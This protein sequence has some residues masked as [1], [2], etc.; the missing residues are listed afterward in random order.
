MK[1][2][3]NG[4]DLSQFYTQM[5][6][7]GDDKSAARSLDLGLVVSGTDRNLPAPRV[8]MRDPVQVYSDEGL[9]FFDG[10]VMDKEKSVDSNTM[11]VNCMD[12]LIQANTSQGSFTFEDKDPSQIASEALS[13]IGLSPGTLE[14][15]SPLSRQF[16]LKSIYNIVHTAYYL[17]YEKSGKPFI[18][19]MNN[20]QVEVVEKG[21]TMSKWQLDGAYNLLNATYGESSKDAI[22]T[23]RIFD[24]EGKEIG[25]VTNDIKAGGTEIYRQEKDEDP[26]ARA[27]KLLKGIERRASIR[28]LGNFDLIT[29]NGVYIKEPF[30]GLI[31]KFFITGDTHTFSD[32]KHVV[33]LTLSYEN[34]MENID[35]SV[36]DSQGLA[37][38]SMALSGDVNSKVLQA[39]Q[40]VHGA[41]YKWGGN[42]PKTGIDCSG[43]VQWSYEQ[44]GAKI[45]GR[46]TS[47]GLRSNPKAYGFVEIPFNERQAGD[48]LWQQG[49][50][51]MDYGGGKIIESGGL[52]K[53][54]LG[55]SGVAISNGKG[56]S[57]SKAYR[58]VGG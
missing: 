40:T 39:G 51:A 35:T 58:Y 42:D 57:F 28:A 54:I 20:G 36:D 52:S 30:T 11:T 14:T 27:K 24:P 7:A 43:F 41:K 2:I 29:G 16:D 22:S 44:S 9:L 12:L 55:Y 1:L 38:G 3:I 45:P 32:N 48:V 21:K 18:I 17:E 53:N 10:L 5:T 8:M 47:A 50:L 25:Q 56:R 31:G 33:E 13:S 4:V 49:H 37:R 6:W 46:L 19:R 23:V 26:Q 15:G 34:V